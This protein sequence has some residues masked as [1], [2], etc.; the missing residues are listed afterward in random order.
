M[1]KESP[2]FELV[3][4]SIPVFMD[5]DVDRADDGSFLTRGE[6]NCPKDQRAMQKT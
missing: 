1:K 5:R 2:E 6:P 3:R 4:M